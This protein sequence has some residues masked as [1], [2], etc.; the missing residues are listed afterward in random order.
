MNLPGLFRNLIAVVGSLIPLLAAE[1]PFGLPE[2]PSFP[3]FLGGTLPETAPTLSGN[4]T[5]VVAFPNLT[6][7]N[8][9]GLLPVPGTSNLVVYEREG[10]IYQFPNQRD[11]SSKTLVLD[12]SRQCQ[13]WDDSGLMGIAYHPGFETN[14]YLFIYYTYVAPGTVKG[15]AN[16]RPPTATPNRDRLER[17]TL[18]ASGVAIP[19]SAVIFID[20]RAETVW[21][22]GGGMFFHPQNGFLYLTNGDD[23]NGGNNQRIN[24]SLH[25]GVL[26]IDV[27]QR[28]G[29]ISHPIPRQPLPSGS[30][31]ANYFI[32]ND[33][34][35]VGRAQS[36]EEFFAIGLR[37]PH[38][39]TIDP[40]SGRIFIGDVG[41][42]S[43]EELDI[44]EP[45]DPAGLN[46]QWNRIE[47]L[48]GDLVA[49][50]IGVNRRPVLDYPRSDGAAIIGGYVYRGTEFASELGGRYVFGDNIANVVW[51][52]DES[53]VPAKKVFLC[54]LPRGTGPNAGND[55][56]GLSGFGYDH[57]NELY[58][59][60]LSSIAGRIYKLQRGGAPVRPLPTLLSQT[61]AFS[62]LAT[63]TPV[64]GLV[65]YEV[66][67]PLW[68]DGAHKDRWMG[69]PD[70]RKIGFATNGEWTFPAGSVW[71]KHFELS[72]NETNPAIRRR[73]ETR[74][75]VRDTNGY[76]YGASYKWRPDLSDAEIV[77]GAIS[78]DI[79]ITG[80]QQVGD[81]VSVDIGGPV[82]GATS[83]V[84]EA[85]QLT[86]GGADI[87]GTSD[88]FRY[89]YQQREGDFDVAVRVASVTETDL[90][91]KA[92][93]MVR[94]SLNANARHIFALVFPSNA[95]RNNNVGGYE[96]QSRD[97][98][99]GNASAIYPPV[100]QPR[101]SYPDTWLR[102]KRA[103]NVWT[104]YSS[105]DGRDWRQYASKTLSLPGTVYFG[106]ALTAHTGSGAKATARFEFRERW[107]QPWFFP[108]RQD[109]L[110]CHSVA[111]GGVLGVKTRQSNRD[112]HFSQGGV[113]DNQLRAWNHVGYF[114]PALD[115]SRIP[116][117]L[118]LVT[119]T[120]ETASLELRAR[121]YLDANCSH[122]HRPGGPA[123]QAKWDARIETPL[124]AAQILG[125]SVVDTLGV[126]G[127]RILVPQDL[128]HSV[129]Y[130]RLGTATE[131]YRMPPLAKNVVDRDAVA[132][133]AAWIYQLTGLPEVSLASPANG[134]FFSTPAKI[135][136][137]A[138][139]STT[140]GSI[141][142]VEFY[143][144]DNKLGEAIEPPYQISWNISSG[145]THEVRALATDSLG[146]TGSSPSTSISLLGGTS[147]GLLGEYFNTINLTGPRVVRM[148]PVINFDWGNGSPMEAIQP[149]NFSVRWTGT[150][151]PR[152]SELYTF[153][154]T[155]DDG[156]RLWVNNR[157]V[158]NSWID[159]SPTVHRGTINLVAGRAVPIRME[160]Y[161]N[162]GGAVAR[163][164]WSSLRQ[165]EQNLPASALRPPLP[166]SQAPTV[167]LV[168]PF[169]GQSFLDPEGI[170]L[171]AE[172][173]DSN[174]DL[175]VV[176]FYVDGFKLG[177]TTDA[178]F[179]WNWEKAPTGSHVLSVQA[180][181][182]GGLSANATAEITV[183]RAT[184]PLLEIRPLNP[185]T[186]AFILRSQA[187]D[188]RQFLLEASDGLGVWESVA[189]Q[190][191]SGG[192]V[193]FSERVNRDQRF[194]RIVPLP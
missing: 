65:H 43:F 22:N 93:L 178:P 44:I 118:Q 63:L 7:L 50:Y 159:Q 82:A 26:R 17:Y 52:L 121:S 145:G 103:G 32:P 25:S 81:L 168:T 143:S 91:T 189:T 183:V 115:E 129:M 33:N 177:E 3:A 194:Y 146:V 62:D 75:L 176:E 113:T 48:R 6:F 166:P 109:C 100:P 179:R 120:N 151:T 46:F 10:R 96:F 140:N 165:T 40:P 86:A 76:V 20:Q 105:G 108:G 73:L 2:R 18:D 171:V 19:G 74:L 139:A 8:P 77:Q 154:A 123:G 16:A 173:D 28:G 69:I 137:T 54:T 38:R 11:T 132:T 42:G 136:L 47:G 30:V 180:R 37:S 161:E 27:D 87:W 131:S 23:A 92:G 12:I 190:T 1:A 78:E 188:G 148:D 88:Q 150:V 45:N 51:V 117:L 128:D 122:C 35:F 182:A 59:C 39:M 57:Q 101:V 49:P 21:H 106:L 191:A 67:S 102:L 127:S 104:A 134:A 181:D 71:V 41:D 90:Y 158:I 85:W 170:P 95:P 24:T 55:Y 155:V 61:G 147:G 160:F 149:D 107:K 130:K 84:G 144:G 192:A 58:L 162:G 34:P 98:I 99:G 89:A 56:V 5:A 111:A 14:R 66:N 64:P 9:M 15:S 97:T 193:E 141:A 167:T 187:V 135:I 156:F 36:L 172:V 163:V 114:E 133:L 124:G 79:E 53:T 175:S 138:R 152:F 68:S 185:E 80:A 157:M 60:Q 94:D 110:S 83:R 72:V 186:G 142:R 184:P 31:T 125:G 126:P 119:V 112:A 29:D 174:G 4:W 13:G 116:G 169:T 164:R 70:G 153:I